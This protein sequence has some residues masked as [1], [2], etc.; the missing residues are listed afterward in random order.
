MKKT[1][2]YYSIIIAAIGIFFYSNYSIEQTEFIQN[3][4]I[5]KRDNRL[6]LANENDV[7]LL[8]IRSK[9]KKYLKVI[10]WTSDRQLG[11]ICGNRV[12]SIP[13]FAYRLIIKK[14]GKS[15]NWVAELVKDD[16]AFDDQI[17][18]LNK[19]ERDSID[20]E[21]T[22]Y[23]FEKNKLYELKIYKILY[24]QIT[25][26]FVAI[27]V[28][29]VI[30]IGFYH[31]LVSLQ[32]MQPLY[33][34]KLLVFLLFIGAWLFIL[35]PIIILFE[36][37]FNLIHHSQKF[38][39]LISLFLAYLMVFIIFQYLIDRNRQ[40]NFAKKE[41]LT[42]G[43]INVLGFACE[44]LVNIISTDIFI[45]NT[46][47]HQFTADVIYSS[48]YITTKSYQL[49]MLF[50]I[51]N[52]IANL[53]RHIY[54][55]QRKA[56]L[57]VN[58]TKMADQ[59]ATNL[60]INESRINPHFLYNALHAIASIAPFDPVNTERLALSLSTYYKYCTRRNDSSV[61]SISDEAEALQAYLE[62]QQVRYGDKLKYKIKLPENLY[63]L[64]IPAFILQPLVENAI[65][66]GYD[67]NEDSIDVQISFDAIGQDVIIRVCDGGLPFKD[68]LVP[69]EGIWVVKEILKN[70]YQDMYILSF[71]NDPKKYVEIY[72]NSVIK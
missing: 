66:H 52:F 18:F 3:Q 60:M 7:Y 37:T 65:L 48:F 45:S 62:V 27:V 47:E 68:D 41:A 17:L 35:S 26:G 46:Y 70:Y 10:G 55:L 31:F 44:F 2:F 5:P 30:L 51:A 63:H 15:I 58:T 12:A 19:S 14:E 32:A 16:Y 64:S 25:I 22:V 53:T 69:G 1:I 39:I 8:S 34:V 33:L 61:T 50:A 6:S 40:D 24:S 11:V 4:Y 13:S 29:L 28:L 57:L 42:F 59:T 67:Q 36:T 49:W 54:S 72:L 21:F 43:M 23:G 38:P 20:K 9:Y 71:V 56:N